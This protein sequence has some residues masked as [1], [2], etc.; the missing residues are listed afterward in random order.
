[1]TADSSS[2]EV[3]GPYSRLPDDVQITPFTKIPEFR[4]ELFIETE[5]GDRTKLAIAHVGEYDE[6][7]THRLKS[8]DWDDCHYTYDDEYRWLDGE[9][10]AWTLD[11]G[12]DSI[13]SL[14]REST[15][16]QRHVPV[17]PK[18]L[19]PWSVDVHYTTYDNPDA[20]RECPHCSRDG[21]LGAR[22]IKL[23]YRR[24]SLFHKVAMSDRC[25]ANMVCE[26]CRTFFFDDVSSKS[27]SF[28]ENGE[29]ELSGAM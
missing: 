26:K 23:V 14:R 5:Y 19:L 20:P 8:L 17:P 4:H 12:P 7:V 3:S 22:E 6:R 25:P 10:G 2:T 28:G 9:T 1:M 27:E 29:F 13:R 18:D 11:W 16:A 21:L 15:P 24:Y